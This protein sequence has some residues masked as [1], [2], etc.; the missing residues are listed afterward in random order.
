MLLRAVLPFRRTSKREHW[1]LRDV[2]L[3]IE[4]GET[5]GI[6]G[7]NGAG[8]TTMLRML[9]GVSRPS[10]GTITIR[11]RVAPLI[12]GGAGFPPEMTGRANVSKLGRAAGRERGC[13]YG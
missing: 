7:R 3:A 2:D 1:A 13:Q 6:L 12:G 4:P 8:K 11:G 5:V 9:A 10:E